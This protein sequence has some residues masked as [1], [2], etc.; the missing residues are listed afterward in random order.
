MRM[1]SLMTFQIFTACY[2]VH[3]VAQAKD[4]Q[5]FEIMFYNVHNLFDAE[6]DEGKNDW[7]HLP[8]SYP[9][10]RENCLKIKVASFRKNCLETDWTDEKV[11]LKLNQLAEA[12]TSNRKDIPDLLGLAEIEN[13]GVVA[14]LA[15]K[16]GYEQLWV[17]NSPD[18]R[19]IEV[20][21]LAKTP[22]P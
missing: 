20:A 5:A 10:K 6:H 14:R 11:E 2:L 1:L 17:S 4:S 15:K 8:L 3:G 18:E 9:G 22:S 19:G 7:E 13:E 21:L 16:L 12:I